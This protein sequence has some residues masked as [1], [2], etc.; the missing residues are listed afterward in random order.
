MLP[1]VSFL[2]ALFALGVGAVSCGRSELDLGYGTT[3]V[4]TGSAGNGGLTGAAGGGQGASGAGQIG[5]IA[6]QAGT[7]GGQAGTRGGLA[8]AGGSVASPTPIPCGSTTC[9]PGVQVCCIQ[10][11]RRQTE[12]CISA[13]A[14]CDSGATLGCISGDSCGAGQVCCESLLAPATMC[15]T[16]EGCFVQPGVILC[17]ADS[18]CPAT[19]SHCCQA[20]G[21]GICASQTCPVGG[22]GGPEGTG[23]GGPQD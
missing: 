22:Q 16:P 11:N 19:A 12:T 18:D 6:G 9:T 10:G 8:G 14:S 20:D 4:M 3:N 21:S 23:T 15:V 1:R 7:N 5:T 17:A 13:K 2:V